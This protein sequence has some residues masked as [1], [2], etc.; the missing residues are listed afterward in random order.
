[1]LVE[2]KTVVVCG[3]G[4]GLGREVAEA[5]LRDGA[6]VVLAARR[7]EALAQHAK[8]IDPDGE[9]TLAV[10]TDVTD[11]DQC[12]ALMSAASDRFG[13]VDAV[14]QVAALDAVFG[15]LES[16]S[17][18]DYARTVAVNVAGAMQIARAAVPFMKQAGGGS[19]VLVGSQSMWYPPMAPQIAYASSKGGLLSAMYHMVHELGPSKIRVNMVIPTWMWG[20]PVEAFVR[21]EAERRGVSQE[22]VIAGITQNMPLGE[23]PKDDD[24]ANACIFFCSDYSRMVTGETLLVNAGEIL[25]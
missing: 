25:R 5:A 23:I 6:N 21:M 20:P 24:V 13:S 22:E 12:R 18:E 15:N 8:E 4:A 2:S 10:P 17:A 19:I 3:V 14:V 16:T 9:R 1:M 11:D 7:A